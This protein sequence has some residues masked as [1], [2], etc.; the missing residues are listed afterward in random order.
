MH[1]QRVRLFAVPGEEPAALDALA[2]RG[3]LTLEHL[4]LLF[5][6]VRRV[7]WKPPTARLGTTG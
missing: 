3:P 6:P 5:E 2:L 7:F 1:H 4:Q